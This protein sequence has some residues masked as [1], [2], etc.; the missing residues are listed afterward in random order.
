MNMEE[1]EKLLTEVKQAK[2]EYDAFV[3]GRKVAGVRARK[4]LQTVKNLAHTIRKRI[5]E[6]RKHT[7]DQNTE[8]TS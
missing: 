3:A 5:A 1:F 8:Q 4:H 7:P 2:D 6:L